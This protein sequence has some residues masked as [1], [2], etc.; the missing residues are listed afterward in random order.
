MDVKDL[1]QFVQEIVKKASNLKDKYTSEKKA[2]VNYACVF[3]QDEEQYKSLVAI[4][5]KIGN[6]V[7]E[8]PTGPLFHIQSLDT[9]AGKLQLLKIRKPDATRP[10]LGDADFTVSDYPEFK[11]KY[12]SQKGFKL[13]VRKNFEMIELVDPQFNVRAYFSN[14]SLN[15]ELGIE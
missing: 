13:I 2:P 12:L 1:G 6:V 8:T 7:E 4:T 3:C 5:Q 15:K 14:P 9:N 10:E 11:K